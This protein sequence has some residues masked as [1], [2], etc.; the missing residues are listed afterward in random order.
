MFHFASQSLSQSAYTSGCRPKMLIIYRRHNPQKCRFT[1]RSEFRCKCPIW[2]SG[3]KDGRRI[4]EALKSRDWN[5]AQSIVRKWDVDGERPKARVRTTVEE[6]KDQFLKDAEARNLSNGT[7]RLYK[8]L[9]REVLAFTQD[10]GIKF[11]NDLGLDALTDFRAGWKISPL[12]ASKKLER[13]RGVFKF[14]VQRKMVEENHALSLVGPKLKQNP[15][16]PFP[17]DEMARILKAAKSDEV[18]PRVE[19]FILTM[20]H[21]GLR[22]SDVATLAVESLKGNRLKLYQAKTGEPVSVLLPQDV[23][24]ALLAVKHS[25]PKYFFWSGESR[26]ETVTGFWRERISDVLTIAKVSGHP[27]RFRDTFAVAL[28]EGGAS[29]ETVSI[30]LGHQSV[31]VTEKHYNPWVKTRQDALD[32]AVLSATR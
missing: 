18:D 20:R 5:Q 10:R 11:V 12:T 29:I 16:L 22:I 25:N 4:R 26:L 17:K 1:S 6:W 2:V 9:F 7:L 27:H 19:A 21:S 3:T 24:D 28:L 23:A 31:R 13:L 15:T 30:L 32:R 14:A 8:L